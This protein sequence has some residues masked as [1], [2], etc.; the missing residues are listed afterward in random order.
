MVRALRSGQ[1]VPGKALDMACGTGNYS[2][3]LAKKGFK[4]TGVDIS[5]NALAIAKAKSRK[6]K[7]KIR[8]LLADVFSLSLALHDT[9]DFILDYSLLHHIPH[10]RTKAYAEK[11]VRRL[12][13]GGKLLLVCYSEK[14]SEGRITKKGSHGNTMYYRTRKQIEDTFKP[15][16]VIE[17][18]QARLGKR[19]HHKAHAFLFQKQ[20]IPE[21]VRRRKKT[22]H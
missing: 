7:L 6:A 15:L 9:F 4:V 20:I 10:A 11:L 14:D 16:Q 13:P 8:L 5:E 22:V 17:Y 12:E 21:S 3:F 1:V 2:L 19:R 18:T